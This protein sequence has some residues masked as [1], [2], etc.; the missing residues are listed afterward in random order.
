MSEGIAELILIFVIV[1]MVIALG[2]RSLYRSVKGDGKG[3]CCGC[4][5]CTCTRDSQKAS[6]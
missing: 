1:G 3:Q 6:Q 4:G 2:I 5:S